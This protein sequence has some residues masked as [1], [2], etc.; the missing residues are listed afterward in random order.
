MTEPTPATPVPATATATA[1][2]PAAPPPDPAAEPEPD[3]VAVAAARAR[4]ITILKSTIVA[5]ADAELAVILKEKKA[6]AV[7][8]LQSRLLSNNSLDCENLTADALSFTDEERDLE[9]KRGKIFK[10]ILGELRGAF[11]CP[12]S[13]ED[14]IEPYSNVTNMMEGFNNMNELYFE[15]LGLNNHCIYILVLLVLMIIFKEKLLKIFNSK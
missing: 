2:D 15:K 8:Q 7:A 14:I 4:S 5:Q 12:Q 13:I 1:T 11:M 9:T 10:R 3:P 6:N